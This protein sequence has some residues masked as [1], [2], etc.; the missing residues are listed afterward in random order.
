MNNLKN[1]TQTN[2][3]LL[4]K[5]TRIS[6]FAD[7]PSVVSLKVIRESWS[8]KKMNADK[9]VMPSSSQSSEFVSRGCN[10]NYTA[11]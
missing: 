3:M 10:S 7:A 4:A 2:W 1:G 11:V 6:S 8:E 5:Q 9:A